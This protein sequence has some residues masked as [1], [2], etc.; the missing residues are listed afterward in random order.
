MT[1]DTDNSTPGRLWY[2]FRLRT[3][4]IVMT[5]FVIPFS[6]IGSGMAQRRREK[7]VI[8]LVDKMGGNVHIEE[9]GWL[10]KSMGRGVQWL[11]LD[12]TRVSDEQVEVLRNAIPSC[13][14]LHTMRVEE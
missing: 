9:A 6:W 4:L 2:Q 13:N 12:N 10:A 1:I 11:E 5:L 8:A 14:I 7:A 3:L